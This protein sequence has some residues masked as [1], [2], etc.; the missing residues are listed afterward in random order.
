M[1]LGTLLDGTV[2]LAPTEIRSPGRRESLYLLRHTDCH[3]YNARDIKRY[4]H[5]RSL[6]LYPCHV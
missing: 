2:S 3:E 1:G 4:L 5:L 6:L